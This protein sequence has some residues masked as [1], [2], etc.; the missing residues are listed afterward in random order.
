MLI[1]DVPRETAILLRQVI[2]GEMD[3]A[4]RSA[5]DIELAGRLRADGQT[6]RIEVATE[7]VDA[8]LFADIHT[9][10]EH[11]SFGRQLREASIEHVLLELEIRNAIPQQATHAIILLEDDNGVAESTELLSGGE[12]RRTGADD[13]NTPSRLLSR[14]E[15]RYPILGEPAIG[16]CLLDRANRHRLLDQRE[17]ACR[18]T[19]R[20][21]E[22]PGELGE[23]VRR[24]QRVQCVAPPP[25]EHELIPIRD[26]IAHGT[27]RIALTERHAAI[28]ASCALRAELVLRKCR[29]ELAPM[30]HARMHRL[31]RR[32]R[33]AEAEKAFRV[34][35]AA[36]P[37]RRDVLLPDECARA[38]YDTPWA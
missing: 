10:P 35:Q 28:H 27:A 19:G 22:P 3:A 37:P 23:I 32:R 6:D 18:L 4:Q 16:D 29:V 26:D 1:N 31:A 2:H 7:L 36:I 8:E 25:T 14:K 9:G 13:G 33:A 17:H 30:L 21:T 5:G 20:R 24:V 15:R 11:D 12:S 38:L 34:T